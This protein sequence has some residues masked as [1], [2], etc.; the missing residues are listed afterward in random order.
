MASK[1][2]NQKVGVI[3]SGLI[4]RSWAML[5][6]G[7]GYN[8]VL[9]DNVASQVKSALDDIKNQLITLEKTGMLRGKL[10]A[11][12]QFALVKGG[13]VLAEAVKGSYY[14]QECIPEVLE[15]KQKLWEEVDKVV[16]SESMILAS[17][18]SALLPSV[19]SKN[20]KHKKQ[21]IVAH[22]VCPPYYVPLV[23]LVPSPATTQDI[24]TRSRAIQEEIGQAP[25]TLSKELPGFVLN[26][27]QYAIL[28][29]CWRLVT[30]KVVSVDDVNTVMT[31]G[32]GRRYA[33]IGPFETAHLN[34]EGMKSYCDRYGKMIHDMVET[35]GPN[36]SW[37]DP[38]TDIVIEGMNK[39]VPLDK[40]EER[41]AWRDGSLVQLQK[42]VTERNKEKK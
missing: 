35:F 5:F 33:F 30:D 32:L 11:A 41:R 12:E 15:M 19:I 34:A 22:P 38:K 8:V 3:G 17:S 9:Y 2:K 1:V 23:E 40:L 29:E 36:P 42:L 21:F 16:D 20:M 27:I 18:T 4:G 13:T 25:V 28:S 39:S 24:V 10:N 26:R 14:I 7:A 6:A 37:F 31:E